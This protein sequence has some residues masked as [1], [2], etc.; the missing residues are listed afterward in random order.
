MQAR[1]PSDYVR[2]TTER[3]IAVIEGSA[4]CRRDTRAWRS[5][6]SRGI[7]G[8]RAENAVQGMRKVCV[9]IDKNIHARVIKRRKV[10]DS[11]FRFFFLMGTLAYLKQS[12]DAV[13]SGSRLAAQGSANPQSQTEAQQTAVWLRH[14]LKEDRE[15][16]AEEEI[17]VVKQEEA[18]KNSG[19]GG[20]SSMMRKDENK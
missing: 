14:R 15:E 9:Y 4:R 13:L 19:G 20:E 3:D 17:N 7:G 16:H 5:R 18:E 1:S 10:L 11:C 12:G 8:D 2:E 6:Q